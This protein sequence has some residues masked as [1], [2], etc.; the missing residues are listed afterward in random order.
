[1]KPYRAAS[2]AQ[3]AATF[4]VRVLRR[5]QGAFA[6]RRAGFVAVD[7]D[8]AQKDCRHGAVRHSQRVVTACPMK[9]PA[10]GTTI[11]IPLTTVAI[12]FLTIDME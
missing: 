7:L 3:I 5:G 4:T 8:A 1:M 6:Y 2:G 10:P 12:S 9:P 11:L